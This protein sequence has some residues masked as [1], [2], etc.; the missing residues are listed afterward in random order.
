[1][2]KPLR[3]EPEARDELRSSADWYDDQRPGLGLEFL[4]AIDEAFV[5]VGRLGVDGRPVVGVPSE[6]NVRRIRVQRFPYAVV[7]LEL[8]DHIRVLAIAHDRRRPGYWQNR[9]VGLK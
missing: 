9:V 3:L 2:N 6:L 5:R 1:M 8:D 4:E 7:F